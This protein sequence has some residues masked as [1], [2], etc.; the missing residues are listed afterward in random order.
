MCLVVS[1]FKQEY[2]LEVGKTQ[3]RSKN[4]DP[5]VHEITFLTPETPVNLDSRLWRWMTH[6]NLFKELEK[7]K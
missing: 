6:W 2:R 4:E 7:L 3:T 5:P 1:V